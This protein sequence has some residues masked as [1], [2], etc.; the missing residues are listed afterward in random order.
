M[1]E[2]QSLIRNCRFAFRC[3]QRWEALEHTGNRRV[4][5]C[6]ECSQDVVLCR[7]D[8]ELQTALQANYCVAIVRPA[9]PAQHTIGVVLPYPEGSA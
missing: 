9:S 3:H 1:S 5:Y 6:H 2:E 8:A 4:R 7:T